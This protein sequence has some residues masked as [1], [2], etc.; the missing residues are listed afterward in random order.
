M[1][2]AY[3]SAPII[4]SGLRKDDFCTVVIHALEDKGIEVFA[5]QFLGPADPRII[6]QRDVENVMKSD[7]VIAEITNPSLGVGMEIMLSIEMMKPLL[8]FYN[9]DVEQLSKMVR[10]T[11]GKALFIYNTLEDVDRIL[12][13]LNLDNLLVLKCSYCE[14][15]VAEV[16][17]DEIHCVECGTKISGGEQ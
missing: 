2:L 17:E 9:A 11:P 14:S 7:I 3:L 12:R 6:Y 16:I 4:H 5:P 8:L 10:G 13:N 1:V 15:Q